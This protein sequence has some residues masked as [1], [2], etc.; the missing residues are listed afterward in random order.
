M[1]ITAFF[2]NRVEIFKK[3]ANDSEK[4]FYICS[5]NMP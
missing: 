2:E 4:F 5:I 3:Y 1:V